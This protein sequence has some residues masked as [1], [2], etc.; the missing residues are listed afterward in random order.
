MTGSPNASSR[1]Q[2]AAYIYSARRTHAAGR[3]ATSP[4]AGCGHHRRQA[5]A[6]PELGG[7]SLSTGAKFEPPPSPQARAKL[8]PLSCAALC[9]PFIIN[10]SEAARVKP[11]RESFR[12]LHAHALHHPS[13]P[14]PLHDPHFLVRRSLPP[15]SCENAF[16]P[17]PGRRV[18]SALRPGSVRR[19]NPRR[20]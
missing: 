18:S 15:S 3:T 14:V 9:G 10:R 12:A 11:A 1:G 8:G 16:S 4:P 19:R 20:R 5:V 6:A 13:S 7:G 2:Q 17:E